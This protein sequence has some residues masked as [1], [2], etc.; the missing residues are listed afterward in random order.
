VTV[1]LPARPTRDSNRWRATATTL[2]PGLKITITAFVVLPMLLSALLFLFAV[3]P[4]NAFF[5]VPFAT[6]AGIG[7]ILLPHVWSHGRD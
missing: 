2:G 5:V 7:I 3:R 4:I 6:F 1:A